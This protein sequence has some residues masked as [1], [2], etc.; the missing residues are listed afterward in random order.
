MNTILNKLNWRYAT[1]KFD[2]SKQVSKAD[3][4][5]LLEGAK[6]TASSY[7]LQPYEIYVIKNDNIRQELRKASYNQ[8]QI[9]DSLFANNT[10]LLIFANLIVG[11]KPAIPT[12]AEIVMSNFIW[13]KLK[14]VSLLKILIV[15][16]LYCFLIFLYT[17]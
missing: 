14:S 2:S 1:K 15:F 16:F 8:P 12:I 10:F 3:L 13:F 9:T 17:A 7:G 11:S 4:D 6:L 5:T